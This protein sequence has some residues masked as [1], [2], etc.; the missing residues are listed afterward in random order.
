MSKFLRL[1]KKD[2]LEHIVCYNIQTTSEVSSF[3]ISLLKNLFHADSY[4]ENYIPSNYIRSN[5]PGK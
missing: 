1:Y 3:D 2:K 5:L 4:L